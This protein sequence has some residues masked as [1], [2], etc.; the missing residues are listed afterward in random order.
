M[1]EFKPADTLYEER[2]WRNKPRIHGVP[3]VSKQKICEYQEQGGCKPSLEAYKLGL[4]KAVFMCSGEIDPPTC[5]I[6][7]KL[8]TGMTVEELYQS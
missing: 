3:L 7:E 4:S 5:P 6:R 8:A 1:T 2:R